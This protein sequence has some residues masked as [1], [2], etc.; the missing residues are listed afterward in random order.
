MRIL[1]LGAGAVG[2]IALLVIWRHRD[3]ILRLV[4]GTEPRLGAKKT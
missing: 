2:A 4:N 3:N 1:V